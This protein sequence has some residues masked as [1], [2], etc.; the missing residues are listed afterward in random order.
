MKLSVK[1]FNRKITIEDPDGEEM[2]LQE[3]HENMITP[4]LLGME[5][6]QKTIDKLQFVEEEDELEHYTKNMVKEEGYISCI[7]WEQIEKK[8]SKKGFK[9]FNKWMEGSTT[10]IGGV[11][12]WDLERYLNGLP[13]RL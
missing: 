6:N 7:P 13:S 9:E 8:M 5:Y 1:Q 11:Y 2:S 12:S 10:P 4:L 3:L